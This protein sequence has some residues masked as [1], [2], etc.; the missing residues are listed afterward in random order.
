MPDTGCLNDEQQPLKDLHN[1]A[2]NIQALISV[3]K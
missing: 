2:W 3:M 1:A